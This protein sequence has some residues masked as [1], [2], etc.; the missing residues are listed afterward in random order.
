[1]T[2]YYAVN[3]DIYAAVSLPSLPGQLAALRSVASAP[4]KGAVVEVAAG[5]GTALGTLATMTTDKLYAVEPS[6]YM[7]VP[8]RQPDV[9]HR[10][11]RLDHL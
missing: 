6:T 1:M 2:D 5:L 11:N 8:H 9:P 3:A 10:W 7:R 4:F